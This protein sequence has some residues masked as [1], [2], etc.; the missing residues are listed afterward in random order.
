M[1]ILGPVDNPIWRKIVLRIFL[2]G[3]LPAMAI[4]IPSA[5]GAG[6]RTNFGGIVFGFLILYSAIVGMALL[7]ARPLWP[8]YASAN[9]GTDGLARHLPRRRRW[10]WWDPP[11]AI[12]SLGISGVFWYFVYPRP[13]EFVLTAVVLFLLIR[14][15][16][17]RR[18]T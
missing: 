16:I 4:T 10:Y 11:I 17:A 3:V 13:G 7:M 1:R 12:L 18:L 9:G 6:D 8:K 14:S 15:M 2:L 5:I